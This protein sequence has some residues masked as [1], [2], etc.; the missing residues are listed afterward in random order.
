[1][2]A[3]R[4]Y[5]NCRRNEK[6]SVLLSF[7]MLFYILYFLPALRSE[8]PQSVPGPSRKVYDP[9]LFSEQL[10]DNQALKEALNKIKLLEFDYKS[11][12]DKRIQD[13]SGFAFSKDFQILINI[14]THS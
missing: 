6:V 12:Y 8:K 2:N 14:F 10:S 11:L 4:P 9:A 7:G 3:R 1:M 5:G 13:V